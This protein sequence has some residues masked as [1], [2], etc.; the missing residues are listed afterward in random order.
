MDPVIAYKWY[1]SS[2]HAVCTFESQPL[3]V[4]HRRLG[5]K[6]TRGEYDTAVEEIKGFDE[7][8]LEDVISTQSRSLLVL[9]VGLN[10]PSYRNQYFGSAEVNGSQI[11]GYGFS[12]LVF[13]PLVSI[14][15]FVI[16]IRQYPYRSKVNR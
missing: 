9:P 4:V 3:I 8:I 13:P 10:S 15:T 7:F 6:L 5:E 16:P 11:Q 12:S 1:D 14:P 2:E